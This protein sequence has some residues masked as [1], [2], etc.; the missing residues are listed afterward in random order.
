[1]SY[2]TNPLPL[3]KGVRHEHLECR[4]TLSVPSAKCERCTVPVRE[5]KRG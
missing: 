1:M 3:F 4:K 5:I 2:T